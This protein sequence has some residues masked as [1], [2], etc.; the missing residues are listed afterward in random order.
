MLGF[1]FRADRAQA[2]GP[3]LP[4]QLLF[5]FCRVGPDGEIVG[6]SRPRRAEPDA[7]IQCDGTL[8]IDDQWVD[9]KLGNFRDLGQQL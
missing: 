5:Q 9:V 6:A 8:K 2:D 4:Q 7:R 3:A 1:V